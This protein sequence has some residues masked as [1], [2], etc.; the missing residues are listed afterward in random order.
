MNI[1]LSQMKDLFDDDQ[2]CSGTIIEFFFAM[3]WSMA[4]KSKEGKLKLV[5]HFQLTN[6]LF[7]LFSEEVGSNFHKCNR[8]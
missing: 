3:F 4:T 8:N 7:D 6:G 2:K 5:G 1:V